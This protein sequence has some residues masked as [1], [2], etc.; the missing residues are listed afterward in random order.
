MNYGLESS[1]FSYL[2]LFSNIKFLSVIY[3][4]VCLRVCLFGV[5]DRLYVI[6]NFSYKKE[7]SAVFPHKIT[8]PVFLECKFCLVENVDVAQI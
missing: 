7:N 6:S 5:G 1:V 4:A 3:Q 2:V 8:I